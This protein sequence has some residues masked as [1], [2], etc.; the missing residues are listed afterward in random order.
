MEAAE[1]SVACR[2][3]SP[4][5]VNEEEASLVTSCHPPDYL[6]DLLPLACPRCSVRADEA[7]DMARFNF[8]V[9]QTVMH[10]RENG[11]CMIIFE[12]LKRI[13]PE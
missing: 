13:Y 2:L 10:D 1:D 4:D 5:V 12:R 6:Q 7:V 8:E 9:C 11:W 3:D